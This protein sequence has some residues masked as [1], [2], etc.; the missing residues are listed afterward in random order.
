M[1]VFGIVVVAC[2][3]AGMWAATTWLPPLD[4][5][6]AG[7]LVYF[8]V[9]GLAGAVL[10]LAGIRVWQIVHALEYRSFGGFGSEVVATG[11]GELLWE[12]GS[13]AAL[14]LVAYL[15]A[16]KAQAADAQVVDAA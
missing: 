13:L 16:P 12:S 15:L 2:F 7:T 8:V 14:A 6:P 10:A 4:E 3:V 11:V 5:G 1:V 9:C